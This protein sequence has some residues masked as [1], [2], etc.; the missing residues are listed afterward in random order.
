[1]VCVLQMPSSH[2]VLD[3]LKISNHIDP[4]WLALEAVQTQAVCFKSESLNLNHFKHLLMW[5]F[6]LLIAKK[7]IIFD[8]L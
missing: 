1:M 6:L 7:A 4:L 5:E 3:M 8:N 2:L